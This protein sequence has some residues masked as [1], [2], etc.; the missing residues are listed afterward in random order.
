MS[1][2]NFVPRENLQGGIGT[3]Q[4][5][6]SKIYSD[7][8]YT[9][10]ITGTLNG[11]ST[12][13]IQDKNGKDI[14]TYLNK[15]ENITLKENNSNISNVGNIV[16]ILNDYYTKINQ[17]QGT[18]TYSE[19]PPTSLKSL[20]DILDTK[21]PVD[22]PSL[23]GNAVAPTPSTEDN[24]TKIATT[25]FVNNL[26]NLLKENGVLGGSGDGIVASSL[27]QNGWVKFKNGLILQWGKIQLSNSNK[28]EIRGPY[29]FPIG[30]ST[31]C[32]LVLPTMGNN[33]QNN[34]TSYDSLIQQRSWN[35]T[36]FWIVQQIVD[37]RPWFSWGNYITIGF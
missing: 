36:Q 12:K 2:K 32:F 11:T 4:K 29:Y 18:S 20:I 27:T 21:A 23:T 26:I 7:T 30:F 10:N 37:A 8:I 35:N 24:S 6:W 22:N 19:N 17:I 28:E 16:R 5:K 14:T 33:D 1:T 9:N 15:E 3:E 25:A 34:W 31:Q 13:A